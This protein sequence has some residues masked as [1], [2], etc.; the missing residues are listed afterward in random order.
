MQH[1]HRRTR[2]QRRIHLERRVLGGGADEGEQPALD[3]RQERILLALV[4]PVHLIDEHDGAL[5]FLDERALRPR[6]Q[7]AAG[8]FGTLHGLADVLDPAQHGADADELRI[9]R[10]GHQARNRGLAHTRRAPQDA[11]MRP[12]RLE[13]QAQRHARPQHM[14]LADDFRE[15]ARAQALGQGLVG[16]GGRFHVRKSGDHISVRQCIGIHR[17]FFCSSA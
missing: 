9:E 13:R 4:E 8:G 15:L 1:I 3:M 10:I 7:P 6:V 11:A 17:G 2:Q 14:L 5:R 12:S 16:G